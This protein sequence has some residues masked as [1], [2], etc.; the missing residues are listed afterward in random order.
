MNCATEPHSAPNHGAGRIGSALRLMLPWLAIVIAHIGLLGE[1][2]PLATWFYPI[3]WWS[4][5]VL[6]DRV[7]ARR[8]GRGL[9]HGGWR[10][11]AGLG[12]ASTVFWLCYELI[13]LRIANWYYV[14]V[15]ENGPLRWLGISLSFAT[16]VPLLLVS[17]QA[18]LLSRVLGPCKITPRTT[19]AWVPTAMQVAGVVCLVLPLLFPR[20]AF[21][22]V[23]G[24]MFLILEPMNHRAGRQALF[25]DLAE[26]S[27]RR[28][29]AILLAGLGCGLLWEMWNFWAVGKWIYTVPLVSDSRLFEMPPLGF[30]GFPPLALAAVSFYTAVSGW[31]RNGDGRRRGAMLAL[32][33]GM[34]PATLFA[35]DRYTVDAPV[36]TLSGVAVLAPEQRDALAAH[37]LSLK[38]L[39]R[40][41]EGDIP[42]LAAAT[43]IPPGSLAQARRW[44][45]L[46]RHRG[47]GHAHATQLWRAGIRTLDDLA[48]QTPDGLAERLGADA[49]QRRKLVVW[50]TAA[51]KGA[52][53]PQ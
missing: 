19:P 5:I 8:G 26:G 36:P 15:P 1:I 47:M 27:V 22:L 29:L 50:I 31:W 20:Y 44:A 39:A 52:K 45:I 42:S 35:M 17:Y 37:G 4:F 25:A 21:P 24:V 53:T 13:N 16:V 18:L 28:L 30:L 3:V 46:A 48:R 49:P 12:L 6:M 33:I 9:L 34:I 51:R 23:W 14:G 10:R 41:T 38:D 2:Q 40:M 11:I 32:A 7:V 43:G